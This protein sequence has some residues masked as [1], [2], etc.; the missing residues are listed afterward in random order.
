M[1]MPATLFT[2]IRQKCFPQPRVGLRPVEVLSIFWQHYQKELAADY[3]GIS[4]RR[5]QQEWQT[6]EWYDEEE[7]YF[8]DPAHPLSKFLVALAQGIPFGHHRGKQYFYEAEF[9]VGPATLIPRL[10]TELLVDLAKKYWT[11]T[12]TPTRSGQALWAD[13]GTG[14]GN[15]L[16]SLLP[17]AQGPVTAYGIDSSP[18]ALA[19]ARQNYFRMGFRWG[20][21]V[22]AHWIQGDRLRAPALAELKFDLITANPPYLKQK[23][24]QG[25]VHPQV[26]KYEP[27]TSLYLP[28]EDYNEWFA[29]FFT[30]VF[31]HLAPQ[32]LFLMEGHSA[33]LSEL[34]DLAKNKQLVNVEVLPDL[35]GRPRFLRAQKGKL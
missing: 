23:A 32:G 13:V 8:F 5:L 11:A 18:A 34:A 4:L 25:E 21:Q 17:Y 20:K 22:Q 31:E 24:H 14:C 12:R 10:E 35:T 29:E 33:C 16:L 19:L 9:Q 7:W 30:M 15:I 3:P 6:T 2:Q 27:A 26:Q 1:A 28:D